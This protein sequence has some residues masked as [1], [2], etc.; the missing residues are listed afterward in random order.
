MTEIVSGALIADDAPEFT[1]ISP[2][3][4][5]GTCPEALQ[6]CLEVRGLGVLNVRRMF[7][8]AAIKLNKFLRLIIHLEIPDNPARPE[9]R[10]QASYT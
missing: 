9:I 5:D 8:D 6:D 3:I 7:G 4:I 2:E 1:Q 10:R